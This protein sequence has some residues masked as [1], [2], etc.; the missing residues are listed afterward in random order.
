MLKSAMTGNPAKNLTRVRF[1]W[2]CQK[3]PDAIN[4]VDIKSHCLLDLYK[5]YKQDPLNSY[6]KNYSTDT[7]SNT[8]AVITKRL[9]TPQTCHYVVITST[10]LS[11]F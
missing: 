8:L 4:N 6:F 7:L 2:I 1:E 11:A 5:N 10:L 9:S 3:W